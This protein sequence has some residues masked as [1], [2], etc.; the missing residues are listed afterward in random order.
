ML[1]IY[2]ETSVPNFLFCNDAPDKRAATEELF[3]QIQGGHFQ[4]FISDLYMDEIGRVTSDLLRYQLAGVPRVYGLEILAVTKECRELARAYVDSGAFT[5]KNLMDAL[6]VAV[7]VLGDCDRIVSW[8]FQH[9]V[10]D[11]TMVRIA[12][13]NIQRELGPVLICTPEEVIQG[14]MEGT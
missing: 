14:E 4:A 5:A 1:E 8:N 3:E 10:R 13:V 9:I 12:E 2:L 6:H 11:W 7:A